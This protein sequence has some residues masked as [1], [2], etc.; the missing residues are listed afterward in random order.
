[1]QENEI[2]K[3]S[4]EDIFKNKKIYELPKQE[5]YTGFNWAIDS[6]QTLRNEKKL[7]K[8]DLD[9]KNSEKEYTNTKID[10]METEIYSVRNIIKDFYLGYDSKEK[11]IKIYLL[12]AKDVLNFNEIQEILDENWF[13]LTK[14]SS[15]WLDKNFSEYKIDENGWTISRIYEKTLI[16]N[17]DII[18]KINALYEIIDEELENDI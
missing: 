6:I 15:K 8:L 3:K 12:T 9:Y 10:T 17:Y 16:F 13:K 11:N 14:Y 1:M 2:V 4:I 5:N 7:L 18:N